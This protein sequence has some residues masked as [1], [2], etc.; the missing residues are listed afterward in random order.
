MNY[1]GVLI[2]IVIVCGN[3]S[4]DYTDVSTGVYKGYQGEIKTVFDSDNAVTTF[5]ITQQ[6]WDMKVK[7][8]LT[9]EVNKD[10]LTL[11][12]SKPIKYSGEQYPISINVKAKYT[13]NQYVGEK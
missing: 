10:I 9:K 7:V 13:D 3:V 12:G 11:S 4:A 2:I 1:I 8:D 6:G 5:K